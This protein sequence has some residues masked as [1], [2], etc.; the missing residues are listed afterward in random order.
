MHVKTLEGLAGASTNV[1]LLNTPFKVYKEARRRGDTAVME[2]AMGYVGDF[3]GKAEEYK[4]KAREGMKEEA[5]RAREKEKEECEKAL[6][7]RKEEQEKSEKAT[8]E[9]GGTAEA[10]KEETKS[11]VIYAKTGEAERI[12][13]EKGINIS[14]QV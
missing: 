6:Q 3:S 14:V 2:R 12:S 7:K 11:P 10:A 13:S 9:S 4:T 1:K 8:Q 5:Q